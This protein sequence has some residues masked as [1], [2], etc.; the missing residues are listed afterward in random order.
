MLKIKK[1]LIQSISQ[2][3]SLGFKRIHM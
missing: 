1:K 2:K 3:N